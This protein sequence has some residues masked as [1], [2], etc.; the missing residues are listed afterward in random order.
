VGKVHIEEE[1][2]KQILGVRQMKTRLW[3]GAAG[4]FE[5][6]FIIY[7]DGRICVIR[8]K[9]KTYIN[10]DPN[11]RLCYGTG[12]KDKNGKDIYEGDIL[13]EQYVTD[14]GI[15]Y[16]VTLVAY[17]RECAAFVLT[18]PNYPDDV[19]SFDIVELNNVEI[20]GNIFENE[21]LLN[22]NE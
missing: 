4:K 19:I 18:H 15:D 1:T 3:N 21:E 16:D 6:K 20:I 17:S 10:D 12:L 13:K 11:F 5:D 8:D 22:D 9:S 14:E 7:N 2:R